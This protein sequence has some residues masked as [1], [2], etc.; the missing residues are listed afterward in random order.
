M[1]KVALLILPLA[2]LAGKACA[3]QP[4]MIRNGGF[5]EEGLNG[6]QAG[7]NVSIESTTEK[8][9]SGSRAIKLAW[10]DVTEMSWG[11][12]GNLCRAQEII[13]Q[14]L[15]E[16]TLIRSPGTRPWR[17]VSENCFPTL[18]SAG[19]TSRTEER[20]LPRA[21]GSCPISCTTSRC[22]PNRSFREAKTLSRTECRCYCPMD[23]SFPAPGSAHC[24]TH[25]TFPSSREMKTFPAQPTAIP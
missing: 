12:G 10:R 21:H 8:V 17:G 25:T 16:D 22:C 4:S 5:E 9:H 23:G 15:K 24:T 18:R 19:G 20:A 6:W 7:E 14:N 11:R 3:A 2:L 13:T 1:N